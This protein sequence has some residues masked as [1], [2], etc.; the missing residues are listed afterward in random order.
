MLCKARSHLGSQNASW[1]IIDNTVSKNNVT[2]LG[3]STK[4][5]QKFV[6]FPRMYV[7][8]MCLLEQI[9]PFQI[10]R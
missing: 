1:E 3:N 6:F 10:N 7:T 8:I 2:L 4:I 9:Q 5:A